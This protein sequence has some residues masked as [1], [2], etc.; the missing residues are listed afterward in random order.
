MTGEQLKYQIGKR[1]FTQKAIADKL[2]ITGQSL[3][4]RLK[5]GKD[6]KSEFLEE[7]APILGVTVQELYDTTPARQSATTSIRED[8]NREKE[9]LRQMSVAAMQGLLA[10]GYQLNGDTLKSHTFEQRVAK[11]SVQVAYAMLDEFKRCGIDK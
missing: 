11:L 2:G 6:I 10:T 8:R 4:G 5:D 7:I 3:S 9:L 1:G